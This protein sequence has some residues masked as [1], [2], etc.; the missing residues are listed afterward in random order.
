MSITLKVYITGLCMFV[1]DPANRRMHVLL[2][3]TGPRGTS[4]TQHG[5]SDEVD[6]GGAGHGPSVHLHHVRLYYLTEQERAGQ[7]TRPRFDRLRG[8][9]LDIGAAAASSDNTAKLPEDVY[10]LSALTG[11]VVDLANTANLELA[12]R[13]HAGEATDSFALANWTFV[14]DQTVRLAN[15]VTWTIK[16]LPGDHVRLVHP[17]IPTGSKIL[18]PDENGLIEIGI[19]HLPPGEFE[20]PGDPVPTKPFWP[21]HFAAFYQ[22]FPNP[23]AVILPCFA[24]AVSGSPTKARTGVER[25]RTFSCIAI[26]AATK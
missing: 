4:H 8:G 7:D 3:K 23:A 16:G 13:L 1:P 15:T 20:H 24:D 22:L 5:S 19:G 6:G 10:D 21:D 17:S 18:A 9:S 25:G 14:K 2:P 12:V 26:G 11:N